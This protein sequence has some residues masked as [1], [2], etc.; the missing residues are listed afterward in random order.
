MKQW[1]GVVVCVTLLSASSVEAADAVDPKKLADVLTGDAKGAAANNPQCK[2]FSSAEIAQYLDQP[3]D[4]GQ[5]SAGGSGCQWLAKKD[6]S[7]DAVVQVVPARYFAEP[8]GS[9]GFKPLPNIGT[10]GFVAPQWGGWSAGAIVGEVGIWVN[11]S[12]K[13]AKESAAIALLQETIKRRK[14]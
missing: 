3:V 8:S 9:K 10:K 6:D 12:G 5:N 4:A 1:I 7:A 14:P 11:L 13:T 2:L